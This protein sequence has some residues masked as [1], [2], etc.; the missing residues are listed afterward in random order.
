M[1][2]DPSCVR[3]MP[4][5]FGTL[6]LL[7]HAACAAPEMVLRIGMGF[8]VYSGEEEMLPEGLSELKSNC[9]E[10]QKLAFIHAYMKNM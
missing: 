1:E 2:L 4:L 6:I 5:S 9:I 7:M 10:S 8:G 3:V